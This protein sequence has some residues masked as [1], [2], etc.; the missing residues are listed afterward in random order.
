[1]N[2]RYIV[3][4]SEE[5]RTQLHELTG[6][7]RARVR[8]VKRAQILLAAEQGHGDAEVAAMVGVG[9]STVYRTKRRFV[10][11]GVEVALSEEPR[12]GARRKLTGREET[13]L[14]AVACS[15]PPAGRARWTLELLAGEMVQ[16]TE[17]QGLSR[18]TVRRR[19]AE[20]SLKPWQRKMRDRARWAEILCAARPSCCSIWT[21]RRVL[22]L[23]FAPQKVVVLPPET[24]N[25]RT[26][27]AP[28][29]ENSVGMLDRSL[30]IRARAFTDW[31]RWGRTR[32]LEGVAVA[33]AVCRPSG[34]WP[35]REVRALRLVDI[36]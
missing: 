25:R 29:I 13:L 15:D 10:E 4:L 36:A 3:E 21:A 11:G 34:A 27:S 6:G 32:E 14:V 18:E 22:P 19:L 7:G 12:V 2:I 24:G 8:R 26:P 5:E 16:R 35:N 23:P 17:H 33:A 1:M 28:G 30:D 31:A 9:T 20:Q